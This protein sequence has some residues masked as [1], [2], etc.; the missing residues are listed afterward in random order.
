MCR[1]LRADACRLTRQ[2][3]Q[4]QLPAQALSEKNTLLRRQFVANWFRGA[5]HAKIGTND[6][7]SD[8]LQNWRL[9]QNGHRGVASVDQLFWIDETGCNRHTL[10][11][12]HGRARRG[13]GGVRCAGLFDGQKGR[14]HSVIIAVGRSG[15]VIARQVLVGNDKRRGTRRDD[16]CKFLTE[17][18][19]PAMLQSAAAAGVPHS[20]PLLLMMDNASIHKGVEVSA[21]LKQVSPRLGVAYQPP[22]MPTVNPVELVNNQ[23][24]AALKRLAMSDTVT[25]LLSSLEMDPLGDPHDLSQQRQRQRQRQLRRSV[26]DRADRVRARSPRLAAERRCVRCSLWLA[27]SS[28]QKSR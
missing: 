11:R 12:R 9:Q 3:V 5:D 4:K 26:A 14:N 16:F 18:V 22:Y 24:K 21:A 17:R 28:E 25:R 6:E 1:F 19:G 27:V 20:A 2:R 15:G 13:Q 8:Q 10:L 7:Q 23:L